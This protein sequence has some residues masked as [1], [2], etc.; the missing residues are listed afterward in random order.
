LKHR[1]IQFILVTSEASLVLVN[2]G[3]AI[4]SSLILNEFLVADISKAISYITRGVALNQPRLLQRAIRHNAS[5]RRLVSASQLNEVIA[6]NIPTSNPSFETLNKCVLKIITIEL[7]KAAQNS[8]ME[9]DQP[10]T[11]T[12]PSS[13]VAVIPEVEVYLFS[14]VVTTLLRHN[15][16]EDAAFA[17]TVLVDRIRSFH[18][19]SV[20]I[21]SAKAFFYFS[22]SY[23]KTNQLNK[24]RPTLL[25][26]YRSACL[27]HN[28]LGQAVLLNLLLRNYISYNLIE[29][30]QNLASKAS[31]PENASNNQFCRYLYYMGRILAIQLDYSDAYL[32]LMMAIRKL[33]QDHAIGFALHIHKLVVLVQLLMGDIPERSIFNQVEFRKQLRPYLLLTLAVRNGD[34]IAFNEM[35]GK[36]GDAFKSDHNYTLVQRLGHNVLKTG[37]RKISLSYSRISLADIALKLHLPSART[38]EYICAKAIR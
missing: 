29:Q 12:D 31:M 21:F 20:D 37:L 36:Y 16:N 5:I 9:V 24:I 8:A 1:W 33:P 4:F 3:G 34:L 25:S 35:V 28:E 6:Q 14:L 11:T 7:E 17:S 18:A 2:A 32:R 27:H 15:L 10:S 38:A 22:L 19:R 23:E 30:A 13:P 26:L